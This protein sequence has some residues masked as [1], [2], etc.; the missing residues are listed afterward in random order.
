MVSSVPADSACP[1]HAAMTDAHVAAVTII[2]ILIESSSGVACPLDGYVYES[3]TGWFRCPDTKDPFQA[4]VVR[5]QAMTGRLLPTRP[6]WRPV[7]TNVTD[8]GPHRRPRQARS[9]SATCH[10]A[11]QRAGLVPTNP[12][13][14]DDDT[15]SPAQSSETTGPRSVERG[16]S[17][18]RHESC[19]PRSAARE[20]V[21]D[22]PSP[23]TA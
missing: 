20:G 19:W 7:S 9:R 16:Q 2:P 4:H 11:Q 14:S 12:R 8:A 6:L 13:R 23:L 3:A 5:A 15:S 18:A 1:P 17:R 21:D 10:A 22:L